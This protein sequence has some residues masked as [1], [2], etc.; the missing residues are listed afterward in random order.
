MNILI[1]LS[2]FIGLVVLGT[3]ISNAVERIPTPLIQI[4]LGCILSASPIILDSNF[5]SEIFLMLIIVPILFTDA[6]K[7][8][9]T[10]FW[11]Y[12]KPILL[13]AIAL[14]LFSVIVV[15]SIIYLLIPAMPLSVS[16]ALAAILSPT[17]AVAV[18]SILKGVKLPKGLMQILEGESL[19]NDASGVVSFNIAITA[20]ITNTFSLTHVTGKLVFVVIIG[21]IFATIIGIT[22]VSI[23]KILNM[24]VGSEAN[25]LVL[26][27][28]FT[29]IGVYFLAEHIGIS[30][31]LTVVITGLIY[32]LEK[33]LY[34]HNSLNSRTSILIDSAQEI[35]SYVLNGFVFILLGYLLPDIFIQMVKNPELHINIVTMYIP[36]ITLVLMLVR[37]A[38]VYVLYNQFQSHDSISNKKIFK[39]L[40]KKKVDFINLSR[41]KYSITASLCGVHGTITIAVSL[42]IPVYLPNGDLFPL[43]NSIIYIAS[44][45]VILS[46]LIAIIALPL[47]FKN[48]PNENQNKEEYIN[49]NTV[50]EQI[51]KY[52]IRKLKK[53]R[54]DEND[55]KR[56]IAIAIVIQNLQAQEITICNNSTYLERE[57]HKIYNQVLKAENKKI[58]EWEN[59]RKFNK[60]TINIIKVMQMHRTKTLNYSMLRQILLLIQISLKG[61]YF[62]RAG[63]KSYFQNNPQINDFLKNKND[64]KL[65][66][67]LGKIKT[68]L[69]EAH[70]E[71]N[72]IAVE[73]IQNL[74]TN[75]NS[76]ATEIVIDAYK[77]FATTYFT[78]FILGESYN[79]ELKE[80]EIEAVRIQKA[81]IK[82]M[83][84][85]KQ[86]T[87]ENAEKILRN[88]THN[89][90]LV[91]DSN[92]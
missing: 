43:R 30:G 84:K 16:F 32:N 31:I 14:V 6:F 35:F 27:Q 66:E 75:E 74:R 12:K 9:R 83:K 25:V 26:F 4:I 92:P 10:D 77:N 40:V 81:Q 50:H 8:S 51:L 86:I 38:F 48:D 21:T 89:E 70:N 17:D 85:N 73:V 23:K 36:V 82:L 34:Q 76:L 49:L 41:V 18:K 39:K 13:T 68:T 65:I 29:P 45:V 52:T 80:I 56:K 61:A 87:I 62:T 59:N 57:M 44:G 53:Q 88:L 37:F 28:L 71:I 90:S 46:I 91:L 19:L 3:I 58:K 78:V 20:I 47:M 64:E 54:Q 67:E 55:I 42:L 24:L 22:L 2:A 63:I 7:I 60:S 1:I 79:Q 33:D 15:G 72:N 69:L 11:T 5:N